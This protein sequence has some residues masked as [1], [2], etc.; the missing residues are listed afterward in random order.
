MSPSAS[1]QFAKAAKAAKP[2][3]H[4]PST[5]SIRVSDEERAILRRKAGKRSTGAYVREKALGDELAPRRKTAAKP[6]L[7]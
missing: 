5:L 2:Q 6:S 1:T 7:G 4:R 3:R